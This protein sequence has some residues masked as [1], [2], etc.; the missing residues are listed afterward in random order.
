MKNTKL[1]F[2][3]STMIIFFMVTA[4]SDKSMN[5]T[6]GTTILETMSND[7][8]QS[9]T[10]TSMDLQNEDIVTF[11]VIYDGDLEAMASKE[12]STFKALLETYNLQMEKPFEIDGGIKGIVLVPSSELAAPVEVG[13]EISVV[14]EVLMVEVSN[15]NS[16]KE[17]VM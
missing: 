14:D 15:V 7:K 2:L 9:N 1:S 11:T 3:I 5:T 4:C 10:R 17:N 13:K 8:L 6:S 16:E 12:A